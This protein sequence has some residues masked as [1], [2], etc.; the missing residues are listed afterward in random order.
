MV[1]VMYR[2]EWRVVVSRCEGDIVYAEEYGCD[3]R[4]AI[5]Q[6]LIGS[7]TE[8]FHPTRR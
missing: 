8:T 4:N 1:V 3:V 2:V 5:L 6:E 7:L